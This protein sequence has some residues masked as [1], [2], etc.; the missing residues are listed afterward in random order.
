MTCLS[1]ADGGE[2][3]E[4]K[5]IYTLEDDEDDDG[6][7]DDDEVWRLKMTLPL[8]DHSLQNKSEDTFISM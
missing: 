4:G 1:D 5:C 6:G 7:D 8:E 2:G 3:V